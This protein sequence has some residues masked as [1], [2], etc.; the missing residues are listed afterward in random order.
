MKKSKFIL[1]SVITCVILISTGCSQKESKLKCTQ[2]ASGVDINFNVSFKGRLIETMDFDYD[3]DL[4]KYSDVQIEAIGKQDFC[5]NVK[6][7]M[8]QY[9]NAF[10]DCKQ[11]ITDKHLKV[12]SVLDVD[13]IAKNLLDKM[14]SAEAAKK[15]LEKQG[16]KCTITK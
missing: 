10:T 16:Y 5:S 6:S 14:S 12:Y 2:T 11:E 13:K 9:K 8:S 1:L 7:S 4:S 3:M 15:E